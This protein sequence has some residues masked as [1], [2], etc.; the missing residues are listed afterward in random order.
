MDHDN[1]KDRVEREEGK[2]V[3]AQNEG[4]ESAE[5][6]PGEPAEDDAPVGDTDQHS[7]SDA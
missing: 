6:F 2:D 1:D 5:S 4:S 3:G 7:S